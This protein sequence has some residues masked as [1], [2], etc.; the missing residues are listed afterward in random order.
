M[1]FAS[2]KYQT[3][4]PISQVCQGNSGVGGVNVVGIAKHPVFFIERSNASQ[5]RGGLARGLTRPPN[6][7]VV[8]LKVPIGLLGAFHNFQCRSPIN[9]PYATAEAKLN[10]E[11]LNPMFF[12]SFF[13]SFDPCLPQLYPSDFY[14]P[15][16]P[17]LTRRR[18]GRRQSGDLVGV[19]LGR[20][21]RSHRQF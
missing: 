20:V 8:G 17:S 18:V 2:H 13:L 1:H 11:S 6:G 16:G 12:P 15:Q 5:G 19:L 21:R 9:Q 10:S 7:Q 14:S 4:C 3:R